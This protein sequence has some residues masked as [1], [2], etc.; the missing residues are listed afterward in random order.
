M[1]IPLFPENDAPLIVSQDNYGSC[2][3]LAGFE[4]IYNSGPNGRALLKSI[5]TYN[6]EGLVVR[7]PHTRQSA[8]L[9]PRDF[10]LKY[11]YKI[12][13]EHDV[14]TVYPETLEEIVSSDQGVKTNALALAVFERI[15]SHYF[16]FGW[17]RRQ[18]RGSLDAYNADKLLRHPRKSSAEFLGKIVGVKVLDELDIDLVIRLKIL[19]SEVPIYVAMQYNR[20][21]KDERHSTHALIVDEIHPKDAHPGEYTF[22]LINPWDNQKRELYSSDDVVIRDAFYSVFI[23]DPEAHR[24]RMYIVCNPPCLV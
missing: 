6:H 13:Q 18:R 1:P 3:V 24:E 4:A 19:A 10:I 21:S 7:L 22:S 5:F 8:Y 15:V 9:K 2:F 16:A 23:V 14:F 11:G 20:S 17:E 12:T